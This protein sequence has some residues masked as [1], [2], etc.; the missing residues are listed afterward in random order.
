MTAETPSPDAEPAPPG[1][2]E[3]GLMVWTG[4]RDRFAAA[5]TA[6]PDARERLFALYAFNLELAR[7]PWRVSEAALGEIRLR[8][9]IDALA[10]IYAGA[11]PR[12]HPLVAAL[13]DVVAA[14]GVAEE[15]FTRLVE[16]R[17]R[18]LDPAPFESAEAFDAYLEGTGGAL[19]ALAAETLLRRALTATERA[20]TTAS[21]AAAALA[22]ALRAAPE[23]ASLD[24]TL[25]P[26]PKGARVADWRPRVLSGETP[27]EIRKA[28]AEAAQRAQSRLSAARAHRGKFPGAM[29]PALL[30]GWRAD[31]MLQAARRGDFDLFRDAGGESE[32]RRRF[33]LLWRGATGRW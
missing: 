25:L 2:T 13:A 22:G 26:P 15:T 3:M 4:D 29:T 7:T 30:A 33:S 11:T 28:V 32:F 5:L 1:L 6:P 23:L 12:A 31:A 17:A 18:D 10:E 9:W 19:T 8:W 21:G 24:R 20:A 27:P 16:T 14:G